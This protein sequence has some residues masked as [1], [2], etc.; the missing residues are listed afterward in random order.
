M[1]VAVD[2]THAK[3]WNYREY[4]DIDLS[5]FKNGFRLLQD[6]LCLTDSE[7]MA[8]LFGHL[9]SAVASVVTATGEGYTRLSYRG[10]VGFSSEIRS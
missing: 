4:A 2:E 8:N 6:S 5:F 9:G 1:V 7:D 3:N 10:M